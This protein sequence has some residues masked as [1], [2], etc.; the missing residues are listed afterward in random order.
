MAKIF[1]AR[2]AKIGNSSGYRIQSD[3]FRENPQFTDSKA[4][5]EVID[6]D[7]VLMRRIQDDDEQQQEDEIILSAFLN[8]CFKQGLENN[9]FISLE[10]DIAECKE[11]IEGVELD[12]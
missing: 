5:I 12:D 4:I 3:F 2:W 11:L 6:D 7:T 1:E 10:D 8:F 9:D